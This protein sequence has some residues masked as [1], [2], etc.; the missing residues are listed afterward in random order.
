MISAKEA[1]KATRSEIDVHL[2]YIESK[3]KSA[4]DSGETSVLLD[5]IPYC[6]W[7]KLSQCDGEKEVVGKLRSLGFSVKHYFFAGTLGN[8]FTGEIV[9][10]L[11]ID[12]SVEE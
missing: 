8:S 5:S 2:E 7:C 6:N 4:I 10:G 1:R 3:I 9:I 11:K 12:W